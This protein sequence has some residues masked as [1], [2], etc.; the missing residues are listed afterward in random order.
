MN[1]SNL[2]ILS[3]CYKSLNEIPVKTLTASRMAFT[4]SSPEFWYNELFRLKSFC[5]TDAFRMELRKWFFSSHITQIILFDGINPNVI[6]LSMG[7][8]TLFCTVRSKTILRKDILRHGLDDGIGRGPTLNA[9][10]KVIY[11]GKSSIFV[12]VFRNTET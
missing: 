3:S 8:K 4:I 2:E 10:Q 9:N 6:T 11:I 5:G 7:G 12:M 1:Q